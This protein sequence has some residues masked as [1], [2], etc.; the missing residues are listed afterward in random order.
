[1]AIRNN[2]FVPPR[3]SGEEINNHPRGEER[4]EDDLGRQPLKRY[5]LETN[6]QNKKRDEPRTRRGGDYK[7]GNSGYG[8]C[9]P[10]KVLE[11]A[12]GCPNI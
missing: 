2:L 5:F 4:N 6:Y 12:E 8:V 11:Q 10:R 3:K 1:M 7:K 9:A